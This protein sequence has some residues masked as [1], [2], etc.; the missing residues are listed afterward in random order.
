VSIESKGQPGAAP[1]ASPLLFSQCA[2]PFGV[3][4]VSPLP[5]RE[6]P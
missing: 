2:D 3:F 1:A 6:I 5:P 4:R